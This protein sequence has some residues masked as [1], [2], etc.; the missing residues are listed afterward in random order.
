[1]L[2]PRVFVSLVTSLWSPS[3]RDKISDGLCWPDWS[4]SLN[5]GLWLVKITSDCFVNLIRVITTQHY[6]GDNNLSFHQ[7]MKHYSSGGRRL[8]EF[9]SI[10]K[11]DKVLLTLIIVFSN[12]ISSVFLSVSQVREWCVALLSVSPCL[13]MCLPRSLSP[14]YQMSPPLPGAGWCGQVWWSKMAAPLSDPS[15]YL[16]ASSHSSRARYTADLT[17]TIGR[18]LVLTSDH[19][20]QALAHDY[21]LESWNFECHFFTTLLKVQKLSLYLYIFEQ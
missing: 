14:S 4:W 2:H 21:F 12:M 11:R 8:G 20:T 10:K 18:R 13:T 7:V 5:T 17:N 16:Q 15:Q 9:L 6:R 1:M 3:A 19:L